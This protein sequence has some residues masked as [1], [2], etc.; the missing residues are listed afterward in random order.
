MGTAGLRDVLFFALSRLA[1]V[2]FHPL[3][4]HHRMRGDARH[5]H[6]SIRHPRNTPG[7]SG[8]LRCMATPS[9]VSLHLPS[10]HASSGSLWLQLTLACTVFS[11][12]VFLLLRSQVDLV[13]G[14]N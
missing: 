9:G 4:G 7:Q 12:A 1:G 11:A 8:G 13:G 3:F 2:T 5:L 10:L 6:Q 14:C